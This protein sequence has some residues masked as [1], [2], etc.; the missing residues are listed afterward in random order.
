MWQPIAALPG[1][2][3]PYNPS[4]ACLRDDIEGLSWRGICDVLVQ[5]D[6]VIEVP[7]LTAQAQHIDHDSQGSIDISVG[8]FESCIETC[9]C[10]G[11]A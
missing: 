8:S 2:I 1:V 6:Q 10:L 3:E 4:P 5:G 7:P 9:G 11:Q